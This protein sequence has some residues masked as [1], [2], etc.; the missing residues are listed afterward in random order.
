MNQT[1]TTTIKCLRSSSLTSFVLC[2][3]VLLSSTPITYAISQND[4]NGIKTNTPFYDPTANSCVTSSGSS[5]LNGSDPQEKAYDY[6]ISKGLTPVATAGLVGNFVVESLGVNPKIVQANPPYESNTLPDSILGKAGYGIAQWT[7]IDRQ[8]ALISSAHDAGKLESDLGVQLDYAWKEIT[9]SYTSVLN[10]AK[11]ATTPQIAA[12]IWMNGYESPAASQAQE[13]A[14]QDA[15]VALYTAHG[16]GIASGGT[17]QSTNF[18]TSFIT[19]KQCDT[20][21]SYSETPEEKQAAHQWSNFLYGLGKSSDNTVCFEGCGP[22]AMAMIIT[23]MTGQRVTPDMTAAYGRAHG[24]LGTPDGSG[25]VGYLL[26][27]VIGGHWGLKSTPIAD[28]NIDAINRALRNGALI[29][30]NGHAD[31]KDAELN[32][33]FSQGGHFVVIRA[34]TADGKWLIGNSGGWPDNKAYD[35]AWVYANTMTQHYAWALTKN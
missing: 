3:V 1:L 6:F 9:T 19:Y 20:Y 25:S 17:C 24:T 8:K 29:L 26:G 27:P 34:V 5:A 7:N 22:S 32:G 23:N 33:P 11:Q 15:A 12:T 30:A 28:F 31:S 35:P 2:L 14:R 4:L 18:A 16:T 21:T 10:K 13:K